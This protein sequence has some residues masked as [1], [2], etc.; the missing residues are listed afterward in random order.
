MM[1]ELIEEFPPGY[2]DNK[3]WN[4]DYRCKQCGAPYEFYRLVSKEQN[5]IGREWK[6]DKHEDTFFEL[7]QL[8]SS[9][10]K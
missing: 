8:P 10:L 7:D 5:I 1:E 3:L 2:P 4:P 9:Q 6:C